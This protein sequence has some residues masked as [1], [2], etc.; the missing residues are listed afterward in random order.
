M[1]W[2]KKVH[3]RKPGDPERARCGIGGTFGQSHLTD[4]LR[5]V[6][7]KGCRFLS[8]Y[9]TSGKWPPVLPVEKQKR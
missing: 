6:T 1:Q 8:A 5:Q 2:N 9:D 4:D 3:L 7:C